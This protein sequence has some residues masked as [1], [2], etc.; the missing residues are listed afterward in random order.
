MDSDLFLDWIWENCKIVY[1][2]GNGDYPLEHQPHAKKYMQKLIEAE[3][4]KSKNSK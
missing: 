2:P 1:H 4:I 3:F